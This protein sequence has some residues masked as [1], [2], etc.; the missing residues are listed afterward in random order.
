MLQHGVVHRDL[1]TLPAFDCTALF[2][3][4]TLKAGTCAPAPAPAFQGKPIH[5]TVLHA[6]LHLHFNG[7]CTGQAVT[8]ENNVGDFLVSAVGVLSPRLH[9]AQDSK[10]LGVSCVRGGT[11]LAVRMQA[12]LRAP[13]LSTSRV[14]L[15]RC[16][17]G[18]GWMDERLSTWR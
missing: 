17:T 12:I 10:R 14:S 2:G 16:R 13:S 7:R 3:T 4:A 6:L 18:A 15:G 11:P 5:Q 9:A 8:A 1:A